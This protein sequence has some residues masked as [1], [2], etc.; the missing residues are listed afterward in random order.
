MLSII[1]YWVNNGYMRY[2]SN[3]AFLR[4]KAGLSQTELAELASVGQDSISFIERGLRKP[5]VRTK[6][7]I[8]IV[9][10]EKLNRFISIDEVFLI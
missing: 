7:R 5:H 1:N 4:T 3:L 2:P 10:S 6:R 8:T 9:L